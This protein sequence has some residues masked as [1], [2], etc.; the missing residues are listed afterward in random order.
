MND[1]EG[2]YAPHCLKELETWAVHRNFIHVLIGAALT[3]AD[4]PE[5][6]VLSAG[7][8]QRDDF[9]LMHLAAQ[10]RA[11]GKPFTFGDAALKDIVR[12]HLS[13]A[14]VIAVCSGEQGSCV[15]SVSDNWENEDPGLLF[16]KLMETV[17][18][19]IIRMPAQMREFLSGRR[20]SGCFLEGWPYTAALGHC[21]G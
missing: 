12:S 16:D 1:S 21:V 3:K 20:R 2:L 6:Q 18:D 8:G 17:I 14:H 15:I 7:N 4:G 11:T 9:A 19:Q 13:P 10:G 5:L